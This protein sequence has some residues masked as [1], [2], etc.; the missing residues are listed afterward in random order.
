MIT[1]IAFTHMDKACQYYGQEKKDCLIM[2]VICLLKP[3]M[4]T[5]EPTCK[6]PR[7]NISFR[8]F[9]LYDIV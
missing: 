1:G 6:T 3:K 5:E 2:G 8:S 9:Y 7:H 4:R